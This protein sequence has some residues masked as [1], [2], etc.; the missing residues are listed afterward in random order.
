[1]TEFYNKLHNDP[2]SN[3]YFINYG[4]P[5]EIAKREKQL[6]N[7]IRFRRFN[8]ARIIFVN[9]GNIGEFKT[10]I[11]IVPP[12]AELPKPI[13]L[14]TQSDKKQATF[15]PKASK[16]DDFGNVSERYY[17]S[18]LIGF[19]KE[20]L[21]DENSKGVVINFIG[22]GDKQAR[23]FDSMKE[24]LIT[25]PLVTENILQNR[26]EFIEGGVE[27]FQR[28]ELWIVPERAKPPTPKIKRK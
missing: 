6:E 21:R 7:F 16:F 15:V 14:L 8:R 24:K 19:L 23:S 5:K 4:T 13:G 20:L 11:W 10:V 27:E 26:I 22:T 18:V 9:G 2:T 12:G 1:M 3:G 17:R 25:H 28:T